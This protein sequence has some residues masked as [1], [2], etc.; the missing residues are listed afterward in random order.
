MFAG[1]EK[2]INIDLIK[3]NTKYIKNMRYMFYGCTDLD[4]INLYSFNTINCIDMIICL[5]NVKN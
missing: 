3:F 1:S 5:K 4:N 2:I